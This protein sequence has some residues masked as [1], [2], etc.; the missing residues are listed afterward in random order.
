MALLLTAFNDF[1]QRGYKR[2][3]LGVDATNIT[4]A[5]RLYEKAGMHVTQQYDT[6][7]K[8]LRL[9]HDLATRG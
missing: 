7:E 8:E 3:G 9:G 6:Y 5:T 2:V 1:H 4:N